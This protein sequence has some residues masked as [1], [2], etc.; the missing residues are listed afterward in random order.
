MFNSPVWVD[1]GQQV[2]PIH[3]GI[4]SRMRWIPWVRPVC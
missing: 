2:D 1:R 3:M 4:P